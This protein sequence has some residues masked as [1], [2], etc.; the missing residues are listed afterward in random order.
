MTAKDVRVQIDAVT[1]GL[2]LKQD[3]RRWE[4]FLDVGLGE[5][6]IHAR[7]SQH[8]VNPFRIALTEAFKLLEGKV[9]L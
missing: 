3:G 8:H 9:E 5:E 7:I 4:I 6:R 1:V 2:S